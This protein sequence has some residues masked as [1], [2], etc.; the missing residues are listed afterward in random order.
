MKKEL[1][2]KAVENAY[3]ARNP[4]NGI[5]IHSDAGR[6]YTSGPYKELL[7]KFHAVQSMSDV[8]KCYDNSR[9]ESWF[10]TLKKEKL[11]KKQH[12]RTDS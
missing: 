2:M 8:A 9:M 7:G 3:R 12:C 10:A 11:Y 6:Q 5:I 1:C 4:E